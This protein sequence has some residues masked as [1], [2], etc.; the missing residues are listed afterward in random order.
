MLKNLYICSS[1]VKRIELCDMRYIRIKA[2]VLAQGMQ[3]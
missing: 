2:K 3:D 1:F